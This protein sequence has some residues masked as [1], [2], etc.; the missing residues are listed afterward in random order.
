M[1]LFEKKKKAENMAAKELEEK[2]EL[3]PFEATKQR[4]IDYYSDFNDEQLFTIHF[5]F[6]KGV[7]YD[8]LHQFKETVAWIVAQK[9][10]GAEGI[11]Q[12]TDQYAEKIGIGID[13]SKV[14]TY[15]VKPEETSKDE[16]D[17]A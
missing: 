16:E 5:V 15:T 14:I 11:F 3:S 1:K 17:A 10:L 13:L 7:E 4:I 12:Y 6:E 9:S 8:L 2:E